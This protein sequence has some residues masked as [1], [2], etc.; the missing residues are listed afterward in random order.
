[1]TAASSPWSQLLA[2]QPLNL[3]FAS[4]DS[5]PIHSTLSMKIGP[6]PRPNAARLKGTAPELSRECKHTGT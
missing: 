4:E 6:V 3:Q 5:V 2:V 1:M